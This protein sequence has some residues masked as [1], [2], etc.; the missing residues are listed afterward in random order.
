ML[1]LGI[2][3]F[4]NDLVAAWR[5]FAS[6]QGLYYSS[7]D[8]SSWSAP[9]TI[10]GVGSS[11]GPSLC[12]FNG[13]LYAAWRGSGT[14][15]QL[16]YSSFDGSS[17][18]PQATIP[19][20]ASAIG[21]ALAGFG[22]K[23]YA[24]WRGSDIDEQ[25]YYSSFDGSSW[26]PQAT[27]PDVASAIGPALAGFGNKLYAAWKGSGTNE[28]LWY[29]SFDGSSWAPQ[30][31]IPDVASEIGPT[32]RV[33]SGGRLYAAWK[34]SD[35]YDQLNDQLWYTSFD[36]SSWA[37]QATIPGTD[38]SSGSLVGASLA[39]FDN[40]LYA[41]WRTTANARQEQLD[42]S[43]FDG[44][45]WASPAVIPGTVTALG[46][47]P[48]SLRTVVDSGTKLNVGNANL[49]NLSWGMI[50]N[51]QANSVGVD[52][53]VTEQGSWS[54]V[55]P[56]GCGRNPVTVNAHIEATWDSGP[57]WNWWDLRDA[58]A[59]TLWAVMQAVSN[60]T[61]YENYSYTELPSVGPFGDGAVVCVDPQ[62]LD[63]GHYI[64]AEILI[65]AHDNNTGDPAAQVKVT[66]STD[67]S[68]GDV[69]DVCTAALAVLGVAGLP[70]FTTP[71][72]APLAAVFGAATAFACAFAG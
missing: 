3:A 45:S 32:L 64:P 1:D 6:D 25:L 46:N 16:Y 66:Y 4:G 14:D 18:A 56:V 15:E 20:V 63:W 29:T 23:L 42:Y 65:T 5:G 30:A 39:V 68:G 57:D 19:G 26:A 71:E 69:G 13:R 53:D 55:G 34:G 62:F 44:S 51:P 52:A 36:G 35:D 61:G 67:Q 17:W 2:A 47:P 10:P 60:P 40:K 43:S 59:S 24:A 41:A 12:E 72:T 48:L 8:G 28:Q 31:T 54:S 22:N 38:G 21:P 70:L 33:G 50:F 49:F 9:A 58:F 11:W 27:I 37:P 7:F